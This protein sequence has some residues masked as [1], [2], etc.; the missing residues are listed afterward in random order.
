MVGA[1]YSLIVGLF[2]YRDLKLRDVPAILLRAMRTTAMIMFIIAMAYGFAWL[3]AREQIPAEITRQ[4]L[5]ITDNPVLIILMVNVL[6]IVLGAVMDNISA[7][8]ILSTVLMGVGSQ[9]GMDPIQLGAM[10]VI[11]FAVGMVTPPVGYS[12][13]VGASISGMRIETVSRFLW[14]FL[15]VLLG[16]VLMVAFVPAATLWL[17]ALID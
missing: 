15:L 13:F 9:I 10:V 3:V 2:L 7:M 1:F 14:P 4:L 16:V 17:P 8:V 6:L 12:L 5:A 11:N